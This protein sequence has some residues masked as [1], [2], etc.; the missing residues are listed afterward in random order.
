MY[1]ENNFGRLVPSTSPAGHTSTTS[2][3]K[4]LLICIGYTEF[5]KQS[6]ITTA[7]S[8]KCLETKFSQHTTEDSNRGKSSSKFYCQHPGATHRFKKKQQGLSN[9]LCTTSICQHYG[10]HPPTCVHMSPLGPQQIAHSTGTASGN[11][12]NSIHTLEA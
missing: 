5:S 1:L 4:P 7:Y 3:W 6:C 8:K 12:Y 11:C 2:L 9:W 10:Q